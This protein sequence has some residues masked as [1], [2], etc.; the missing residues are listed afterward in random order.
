MRL[1]AAARGEELKLEE[2]G[3]TLG[4]ERAIKALSRTICCCPTA[5][6]DGRSPASS[7][8]SWQEGEK[9]RATR[10]ACSLTSCCLLLLLA[11]A[12][13]C[14]R[15]GMAPTRP[16]KLPAAKP[17]FVDE[18]L[19]DNPFSSKSSSATKKPPVRKQ[20]IVKSGNAGSSKP[21]PAPL[22]PGEVAPPPPLFRELCPPFSSCQTI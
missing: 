2:A 14:I 15:V 8:T 19:G 17:K 5:P 3:L 7:G 13:S 16:P 12:A 6:S 1:E 22:A 4:A 20:N 9:R 10:L 11:F 21:A 18:G